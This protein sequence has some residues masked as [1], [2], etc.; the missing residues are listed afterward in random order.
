MDQKTKILKH[1]ETETP[2]FSKKMRP[3]RFVFFNDPYNH[4]V[5]IWFDMFDVFGCCFG[6]FDFVS[7]LLMVC[8]SA[9]QQVL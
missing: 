7:M 5:L 3:R 1:L 4:N 8:W 9:P 2:W 6:C